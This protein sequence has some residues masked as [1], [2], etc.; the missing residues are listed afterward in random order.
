MQLTGLCSPGHVAQFSRIEFCVVDPKAMRV[1]VH[2]K[3][4]I[5]TSS[6]LVS[7]E[8]RAT[9]LLLGSSYLSNKP[10]FSATIVTLRTL[11]KGDLPFLTLPA[12]PKSLEET[13]APRLAAATFWLDNTLS[14]LSQGIASGVSSAPSPALPG[15]QR[16]KPPRSSPDPVVFQP[17]QPHTLKAYS[18]QFFPLQRPVQLQAW[19]HP[20]PWKRG[21]HF[22]YQDG[23]P[24]A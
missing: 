5:Y 17:G 2:A 16:P 22:W 24:S 6:H 19:D 7:Q 8:V 12:S 21:F 13:A 23:P 4:V 10:R 3:G 14:V 1:P 20:R 15:F 9:H 18:S 11:S